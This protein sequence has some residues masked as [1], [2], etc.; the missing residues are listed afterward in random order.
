[1]TRRH[2]AFLLAV[3]LGLCVGCRHTR[4]ITEQATVTRQGVLDGIDTDKGLPVEGV[5][6]RFDACPDVAWRVYLSKTGPVGVVPKPAVAACLRGLAVGS[7]V[8]VALE[9]TEK[10][11]DHGSLPLRIGP[12]DLSSASAGDFDGDLK[13][14][15]SRRC[16]WAK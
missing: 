11:G 9:I 4:R 5:E 7:S 13:T 1:M 12:C 8:D 2:G 6:V 14:M 3:A 15:G 16:A 10:L